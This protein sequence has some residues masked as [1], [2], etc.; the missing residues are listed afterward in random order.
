MI[1]LSEEDINVLHQIIHIAKETGEEP[2]VVEA[3]HEIM[4]KIERELQERGLVDI[5][6]IS[7]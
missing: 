4:L 3:A 6:I 7:D 5:K 1:K 2:E